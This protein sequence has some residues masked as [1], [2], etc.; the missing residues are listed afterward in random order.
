VGAEPLSHTSISNKRHWWWE[1]LENFH[2]S[3]DRNS[4]PH[5]W[6]T[7][8]LQLNHRVFLAFAMYDR[9]CWIDFK[10]S[11]LWFLKKGVGFIRAWRGF[12]CHGPLHP[13]SKCHPNSAP[14]HFLC[15]TW[16]SFIPCVISTNDLCSLYELKYTFCI[17]EWATRGRFYV[18]STIFIIF[19]SALM[20]CLLEGFNSAIWNGLRLE[21]KL[22]NKLSS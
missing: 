17:H 14:R 10:V 2:F 1:K 12:C 15:P 18:P 19:G 3:R 7:K 13:I 6:Y 9:G 8:S 5:A 20:L 21:I 4:W 11:Y 22:F 16:F